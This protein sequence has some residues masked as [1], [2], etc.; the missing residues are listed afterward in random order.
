MQTEVRRIEVDG[1][2]DFVLDLERDMSAQ[3]VPESLPHTG[4]ILDLR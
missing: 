1:E 2:G 3:V 4:E